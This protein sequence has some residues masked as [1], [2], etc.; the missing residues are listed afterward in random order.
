MS[1]LRR[2]MDGLKNNSSLLTSLAALILIGSAVYSGL[3]NGWG[4]LLD[5]YN[6]LTLEGRMFALF[7][8]NLFI[9]LFL[10][11]SISNKRKPETAASKENVSPKNNSSTNSK[12]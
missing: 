8:I 4:S 3:I 5:F 9:T 1:T 2:I 6:S 10:F 11:V 12:T 7:F